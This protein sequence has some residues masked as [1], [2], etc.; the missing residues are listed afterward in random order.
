MLGTWSYD[1]KQEGEKL[2]KKKDET[3][4]C[5]YDETTAGLLIMV[6]EN[7]DEK[8]R[9]TKMVRKFTRLDTLPLEVAHYDYQER[10]ISIATYDSSY[11]RLLN[12]KN[13]KRGKI[14]S[15]T[16]N[17]FENERIVSSIVKYNE[18]FYTKKEYAYNDDGLL[19]TLAMRNK[20][21]KLTRRNEFSYLK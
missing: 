4:V 18:K 5:R 2:E 11:K 10:P 17:E 15:E 7:F 20:K 16:I 19:A 3:Q 14:Y 1:C 8:G 9:I 13:Y 12:Y 6:T 21:N